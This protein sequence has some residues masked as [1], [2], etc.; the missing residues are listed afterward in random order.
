MAFAAIDWRAVFVPSGNLAE[1][2]VRA[3]FMYLLILAGFR[4]LRRE[5]GSL[6][7]SDLLVVVL[8]ADAA[9]NGMAGE[10][11]SLTEGAIV[12]A[13]IFGWNYFLDWLAYRSKLVSW[14]V[15]PPPTLL[16]TNGQVLQ[17][18]LRRELISRDDLMEQLREHGIEHVR[19]VKKC[20]LESDGKMSVIRKDGTELSHPPDKQKG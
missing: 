12:V 9:Q 7:V 6:S 14:L 18:N 2:V 15:S 4:I 20:F 3:S 10:Y 13:T 5:A 8:I 17:R 11:T 16:V 19:D 1:L